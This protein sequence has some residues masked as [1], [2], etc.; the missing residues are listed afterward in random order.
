MD[1]SQS[2]TP[3]VSQDFLLNAVDRAAVHNGFY[4]LSV[5]ISANKVA[6]GWT[7]TTPQL[8]AGNVTQVPADLALIH[9]EVS[10]ALEAYRV[11]SMTGLGLELADVVIRVLGLAHGLEIDLAAAVLSKLTANRDRPHRHGGK[12]L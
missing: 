7:V 11:G 8:A 2:E 3:F 5:A 9:S 6:K 10:E 1:E 4:A 12:L